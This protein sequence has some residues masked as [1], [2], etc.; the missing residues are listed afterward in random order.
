M[1]F[2]RDYSGA[3]ISVVNVEWAAGHD[4]PAS[5]LIKFV[6]PV[7]A[8]KGVDEA[9]AKRTIQSYANEAIC[10]REVLP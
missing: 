5:L 2:Y 8:L 3:L 10:L 9:K 4:G 6:D 1:N 7:E